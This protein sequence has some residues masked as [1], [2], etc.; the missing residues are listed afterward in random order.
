M[1]RTLIDIRTLMFEKK[2]KLHSQFKDIKELHTNLVSC[3]LPVM[4]WQ[5]INVN[6][7]NWGFQMKVDW[8]LPSMGNEEVAPGT[9]LNKIKWVCTTCCARRYF[10]RNL[11]FDCTS[12]CKKCIE[13]C[14]NKMFDIEELEE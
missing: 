12:N 8:M 2:N 5:G 11:G 10:C 4:T 9:I 13:N 6:P 7:L 1:T 3:L 14:Q